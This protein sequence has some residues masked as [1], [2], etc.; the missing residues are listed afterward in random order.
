MSSRAELEIIREIYDGLLDGECSP[1]LLARLTREFDSTYSVVLVR[2][3]L[4]NAIRVVTSDVLTE[5]TTR[6]YETYYALLRPASFFLS[7]GAVGNVLTDRAYADYDA[8][9]RSELYNDFFRPLRA[10]HL[11]FVR[12]RR[13]A[14]EEQSL[15][16]RRNARAG[17]YGAA[18]V[19]RLSRIAGH[20]AN[21]ERLLHHMR[22]AADRATAFRTVLDRL[23]VVAFVTDRDG[24]ICYTTAAAEHE[25]SAGRIFKASGGRLVAG[26]HRL[27]RNLAEAIRECA[28]SL[29]VPERAVSRKLGLPS[30]VGRP[31]ALTIVVS[32]FEWRDT[33]DH[34]RP[35]SLVVVNDLRQD[36]SA[37]LIGTARLF[38][39]TPAES[40]LAAALCEGRALANYAPAAGISI[41]TARTLLKRAQEK[42][43]TH[44]QSELVS[45]LLRQCLPG[46]LSL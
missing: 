16:I 33:N 17:F 34:A 4:T 24:R 10:D 43:D 21:A 26:D 39:L 37:P 36:R 9:R 5:E 23:G 38:G 11:M 3:R 25:L 40:R 13:D 15:A 20:L 31:A 29:D 6:A 12:L 19:R 41:L 35:A 32:A 18:H 27:D 2:D 30:A 14:I 45:L 7:T 28:E 1:R 42:T 46:G 22:D 8:Y 44:T